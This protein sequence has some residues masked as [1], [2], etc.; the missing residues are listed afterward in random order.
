MDWMDDM[1]PARIEP[2]NVIALQ[3]FPTGK[4][5]RYQKPVKPGVTIV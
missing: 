4:A 5:K 3:W 1:N 2:A